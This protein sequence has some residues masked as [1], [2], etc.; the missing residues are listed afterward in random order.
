M[1]LVERKSGDLLGS[2]VRDRQANRVRRTI[3]RPY[4]P[5]PTVLRRTL[6]LDNGKEIAQH[7]EISRDSQLDVFFAEPHKPWQRGSNEHTNGL[8]RQYYPKGTNFRSISRHHLARTTT[9]LNNRPPKRLNY[10][11]P[12]E[13]FHSRPAVA[14]EK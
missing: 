2:K 8:L 13:V 9:E 5:L 12:K 3:T 6:T 10:Q 4:D 11:T 1:T 14:F 7:E